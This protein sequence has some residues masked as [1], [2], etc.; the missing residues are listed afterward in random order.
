[1]TLEHAGPGY[2]EVDDPPS[3]RYCPDHPAMDRLSRTVYEC[4]KCCYELNLETAE[5]CGDE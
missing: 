4:P 2:I 3:C 5:E 1:M